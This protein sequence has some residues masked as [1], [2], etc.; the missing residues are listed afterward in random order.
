MYCWD[1]RLRREPVRLRLA[2]DQKECVNPANG[3]FR[4]IIELRVVVTVLVK[5]LHTLRCACAQ[6][7]EPAEHN[8]FGWTNFR[9]CGDE[10]ALLA[11][12]TQGAFE[13]AACVGQRFRSP[14]DHTKWAR[15]DAV[16]AAVANIILHEHR[17]DFSAHDRACWARFEA[18]GF[19]AMFAN[20]GEKDPAER[21][22][23]I[24]VA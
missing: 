11:V 13:R 2:K 5:L 18:T 9:A 17:T 24:V 16:A 8:R 6:I 4:G 3:C 7:V 22:F 21:I 15:N 1:L 14:I 12:V 19:F 10:A 23:S 20:V